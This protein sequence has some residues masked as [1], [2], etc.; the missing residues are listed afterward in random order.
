MSSSWYPG[1]VYRDLAFLKAQ[2]ASLAKQL[3]FAEALDTV[4]Q[5]A[6]IVLG[7]GER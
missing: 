5:A 4:T 2:C 1:A 6:H 7:K 3:T